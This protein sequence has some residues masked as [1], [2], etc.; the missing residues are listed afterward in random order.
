MG[1]GGE[2]NV[3]CILK[4]QNMTKNV[5]R[6]F[7]GGVVIETCDVV[8]RDGGK[9]RIYKCRRV[10]S[11]SSVRKSSVTWNFIPNFNANVDGGMNTSAG[12]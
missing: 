9:M 11:L 7:R 1:W 2:R 6:L 12:R 8:L 10:K 5:P 3:E 4:E